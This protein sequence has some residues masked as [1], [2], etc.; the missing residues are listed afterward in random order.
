MPYH[1]P[2]SYMTNLFTQYIYSIYS[3]IDQAV[4]NLKRINL[5]WIYPKNAL[6]LLSNLT[7]MNIEIR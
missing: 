4:L 3:C 2:D 5:S 1:E 7:T 6:F